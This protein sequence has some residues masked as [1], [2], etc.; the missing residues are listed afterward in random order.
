MSQPADLVL[1]DGEVIT[2]DGAF[3]VAQAMAVTGGSITAVGSNA[4]I[5]ALIGPR[6]EVVDLHGR[7]ALP[8]INDSHLHACAFGITRPPLA[9]DAGHP[10]VTSIADVA[11]AVREAAGR[12]PPGEWIRGN[13][14]DLGYLA[15]CVGGRMPSRHDLDA[16]APGHPVC[17]QDFSAHMTWANTM[18]L[19]LAGITG[20][21]PVPEGGVV[22]R[23]ADGEPSGL[24]AEGA[25]ALLSRHLPPY[26]RGQIERAITSAIGMLHKEGITSYTEP[27]LG[28][29]GSELFGG[30]AGA[31]PL[32]VYAD[33]ARRGELKARVSVLLLFTAM[34]GSAARIEEGLRE[35]AAPTGLDPRLLS[36][37]G[38]KIFAD[39]IPPNKTAWMHQEYLGGGLGCLC[40]DGGGDLERSEELAE[41]VRL[42]HAA[43]HQIGVHVTG[44]R[45]IDAVVGA[46]VAAQ[47]K[48][49]RDDPR[50]Y[51]IHADFARPETLAELAAHGFGANMNPA[52]KWTTAELVERMLGPGRAAYQWPMRTALRAGVKVTSS[53]DAP[54]TY[55]NWR[56][57]VAAM[58]LRESKIS[59]RVYGP[60]ERIGLED[61]IRAYTVNA[62]WQDFA[63]GWKGS[64]E[65]GKVADVTVL[66]GTLTTLDPHELPDTPVALT[67]FNGEVVHSI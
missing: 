5:R 54:V 12:T 45:A 46:F 50:H 67:I 23:D 39:G 36:V 31:E 37:L 24:L 27:G 8:G 35:F 16:V 26:G 29:G 38:V 59:G 25:Q 43:G 44:D 47:R 2:V 3:T 57:G 49:P 14:W 18:A 62:A 64:L 33:F 63:E 58:L 15:E 61:A 42:A 10:A 11:A 41:M 7:T 48:H 19:R 6:T 22:H 20:D 66:D 32:D 17:L 21:T 34:A 30:A 56:Q 51:L 65:P 40:V 28:P 1:V 60:E 52:I 9:L 4:D 53:S 13:G 55:P